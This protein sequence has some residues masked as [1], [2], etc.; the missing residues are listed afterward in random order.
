MSKIEQE[1]EM[2]GVGD[3]WENGRISG[4][5]VWTNV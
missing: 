4:K 3:M 5:K 2:L 1:L